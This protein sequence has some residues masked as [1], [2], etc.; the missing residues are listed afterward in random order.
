MARRRRQ[1]RGARRDVAA[2]LR[3]QGSTKT[4]LERGHVPSTYLEYLAMLRDVFAECVRVLEPGGRIAV[5]VANLG[6]KPYRSLAGD[7]TTIL[8]DELATAAARRGH[9]GEGE[10]R[11]GLVRVR[12]PTMK[13]VEPGAPRSHRAR[14]H[15]VEG[16]LRPRAPRQAAAEPR[17]CR[18][19]PRSRKEEFLASTLDVW[20]IRPE[21]ARRVDHPA[22]FPVELPERLIRLY[23]Y[24]GD[25]VLDPFIGLGLDRGGGGRDRPALRRLRHR[26]RVRRDRRPDRGAR[27]AEAGNPRPTAHPADPAD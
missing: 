10:G 18:S 17:A 8:Q 1:L 3:G 26:P 20:E 21:S 6:R 19:S 22:P 4:T 23:T 15:R 12:A 5:N 16:S 11:V 25:V 27:I 9:L 2:V 14:R 24:R 13:R 7:V